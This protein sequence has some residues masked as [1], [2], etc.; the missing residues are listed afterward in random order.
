MGLYR[1]W[2]AYHD[3]QSCSQS[4]YLGRHVELGCSDLC[5]C[6]EDAAGECNGERHGSIEERSSQLLPPA[7]ILRVP[8]IVWSIPSNNVVLLFRLPLVFHALIDLIV[9]W[10]CWVTFLNGWF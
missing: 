6:A 2:E 7:P 9:V 8:R 10:G 3:K 4:H 1:S 5:C